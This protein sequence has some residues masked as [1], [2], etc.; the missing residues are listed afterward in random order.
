MNDIEI[1]EVD[2]VILWMLADIAESSGRQ[3][4]FDPAF[5]KS[6][7]ERG[8]FWALKF[9]YQGISSA[10][11]VGWGIAREVIHIMDM[12]AYLEE[13]FE[14]LSKEDK[15]YV[16]KEY[17]SRVE[18]PGFDGNSETEYFST[19][20]FIAEDLPHRFDSFKGRDLNSHTQM[21]PEYKRMISRYKS[22]ERSLSRDDLV[23]I[24]RIP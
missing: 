22:K 12:W 11:D 10:E 6:V 18:F 9:H 16:E 15:D 1:R 17:G 24:L 14:G 20:L 8:Q 19:A 4:E 13:A 3:G 5:I 7:V 21:L 23:D 2:K